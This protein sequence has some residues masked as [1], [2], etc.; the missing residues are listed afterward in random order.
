M[1]RQADEHLSPGEFD[2]ILQSGTSDSDPKVSEAQQ[3]LAACALCF[4]RL[5]A[6]AEQEGRLKNLKMA[7]PVSCGSTCPQESEWPRLAAGLATGNE[8]ELLARHAAE[9]DHCG[10]L[11]RASLADFSS[12][13]TSEEEELVAGLPS[14][15]RVWQAQMAGTLASAGKKPGVFESLH[16]R[17]P[18]FRPVLAWAYAAAALILTAPVVVVQLRQPQI[19]PLLVSASSNPRTLDLRIFPQAPYAPLRQVRGTTSR[20]DGPTALIDGE[21]MI[22]RELQKD[23]KNPL[24][25]QAMGRAQLLEHEYDAAIVTFEQCRTLQPDAPSVLTDLASA[26]F[27]RADARQSQD[28]YREAAQTLTLALKSKPDDPIALFNRAIVYERMQLHDQAIDDWR[29]YLRIDANSEWSS[30]ARQRL[31]RAEQAKSTR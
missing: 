27:G 25:L 5:D 18:S 14:S 6:H 15:R 31:A 11:L 8:A 26:Y 30:E 16:P 29:H 24:W 12:D 2:A 3:H 7:T 22:R 28:G 17:F 21:Q 20:M 10:P 19:N 23:P 13:L 4:S 9:C 1:A